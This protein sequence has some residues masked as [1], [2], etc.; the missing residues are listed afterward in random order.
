MRVQRVRTAATGTLF[1][2]IENGDKRRV[3]TTPDYD[4]IKLIRLHQS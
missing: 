2:L 4:L 1:V 3:P